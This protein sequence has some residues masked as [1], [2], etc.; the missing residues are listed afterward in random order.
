[1]WLRLQFNVALESFAEA[2]VA[3]LFHIERKRPFCSG[4]KSCF[5]NVPSDI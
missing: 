2:P 3:N 4:F 5:F 1:M